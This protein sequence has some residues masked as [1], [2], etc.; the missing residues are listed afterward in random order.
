MNL[1]K[2]FLSDVFA[3][4]FFFAGSFITVCIGASPDISMV[5]ILSGNFKRADGIVQ[6]LSSFQISKYEI[7]K[8]EWDDVRSWAISNGYEI[9]KGSG[10]DNLPV[11]NLTWFDCVKWCNAYSEKNKLTPCYYIDPEFKTVYKTG[12]VNNPAECVNWQADGFRLPTESQWEYACRAG[13]QTRYYWG[14]EEEGIADYAWAANYY[15]PIQATQPV[16]LKKPNKFGLYDMSG[17]VI[18]WC[19]N[20]YKEYSLND[21]TIDNA[22][23]NNGRY[24]ILRGGSVALDS[25][26]SSQKRFFSDPS[27]TLYETGFRV[28]S[29][30]SVNANYTKAST[31]V[32]TTIP[33]VSENE[34][35]KIRTAKKLFSLIDLNNPE[36][37]D[38]KNLFRENKFSE[39]LDSYRNYFLN[40]VRAKGMIVRSYGWAQL[41]T[42]DELMKMQPPFRYFGADAEFNQDLSD[43]DIIYDQWRKTNKSEYLDR[44]LFMLND[45]SVHGKGQYD[46]LGEDQL[47]KKA[48]PFKK[49]NFVGWASWG[50]NNGFVVCVRSKHIIQLLWNICSNIDPQQVEKLDSEFLANIL[51]S[52]TTDHLDCIIRDPRLMVPNQVLYCSSYISELADKLPEFNDSAFWAEFGSYLFFDKGI[53]ETTMIDGGFLEQ[54]YNYNEE[55]INIGLKNIKLLSS[56][57]PEKIQ[58]VTEI[59]R[60]SARLLACV[61]FPTGGYPRTGTTCN[62]PPPAIWKE[63]NLINIMHENALKVQKPLCDNLKD[64]LM[65]Q[66]NRKLWID[67]N[68][69]AP[70]F[71]SIAFPYSGY[72]I[73][74][75]G[76][77]DKDLYLFL[78]GARHGTGHASRN[79]NTISVQAY[80]RQFLLDCGPAPYSIKDLKPE[81]GN[82]FQE[83]EDYFQSVRAHNTITVDGY[84]QRR[85]FLGESSLKEPYKD[86]IKA[87]W[88]SDEKFD[89][90]ESFYNDLYGDKDNKIDVSHNRQV[91]LLKDIKIWIIRDVLTGKG[92]H[93]YSQY[94]NFPAPY[95]IN[96]ESKIYN[97]PGFTPEQVNIDPENKN[98]ITHD[99]NGPNIRLLQFTDNKL[100]YNLFYGQKKPVYKGWYNVT[101][102][103]EMLKSVQVEVN[104]SGKDDQQLITLL[105]P[106]KNAENPIQSIRQIPTSDNSI[107]L[108][109][110]S[111]DVKIQ[112]FA[113]KEVREFDISDLKVKARN[114]I[115]QES[116]GAIKKG[117]CLDCEYLIFNNE[118]GTTASSNFEY[119]IHDNKIIITPMVIPTTFKWIETNNNLK[120]SY[121]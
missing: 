54:S 2:L 31:C 116:P 72:Y 14:D 60:N 104:W 15:S 101:N 48:D 84:E 62:P 3:I 85:L 9:G 53:M 71:S 27:F 38:V 22:G 91:V 102:G 16:G 8:K 5:E 78:M 21:P 55:T 57:H 76:W 119:I 30:K 52:L 35:A 59:L 108:E 79:I 25:D 10:K 87:R 23:P 20:W 43:F 64:K 4:V 58:P 42:I 93:R 80:G 121:N 61:Q 81:F 90:A 49:A 13:S 95:M 7:T 75:T 12:L 118:K 70:A 110:I 107:R 82:D 117:F 26:V 65:E 113:S 66:I 24:R 77:S 120:P 40:K 1:K 28:V 37:S 73:Q 96:S 92:K 109:F 97:S 100:S 105:V 94:W 114:F 6:K 111:N 99:P 74:K 115:L 17:N 112:Y 34:D 67:N 88:L 83:I 18:E 33:V 19:W 69:P 86:T 103:C 89:L 45:F 56:S 41:H 11:G 29:Q 46:S 51:I 36:L 32:I 63:P 106:T 39:S 98:I 50:W 47:H 68:A 44:L